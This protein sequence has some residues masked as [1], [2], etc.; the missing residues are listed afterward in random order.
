[1]TVNDGTIS[2]PEL[3]QI[4]QA[5]G[6]IEAAFTIAMKN[7]VDSLI[8]ATQSE[9]VISSVFL[10]SLIANY[11]WCALLCDAPDENVEECCW[12]QYKKNGNDLGTERNSG[13]DY[14]LVIKHSES[15]VRVAVIQAKRAHR[16][17]SNQYFV[18]VHRDAV[19][20]DG[21][22][23]VQMDS[24]VKT[25][26][27]FLEAA[28][29]TCNDIRDIH[30]IHY[31]G[32][33]ESEFRAVSLGYMGDAYKKEMVATPHWYNDFPI[34]KNN[35]LLFSEL[36]KESLAP[37]AGDVNSWVSVSQERAEDLLPHLIHIMD[38]F[39]VE[40][41][42]SG[43]ALKPKVQQSKL[44]KVIDRRDGEKLQAKLTKV[45]KLHLNRTLS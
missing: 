32:Y 1:M 29:R 7:T 39:T 15:D 8:A 36:L 40:R 6:P 21:V 3:L 18:D 13:A 44:G 22:S 24:L 41:G 26:K 45:G 2:A 23:H 9:E 4:T 38:V 12:G 34:T 20:V 35:S 16:N 43:K 37:K 17:R 14:A 31:L 25:G 27:L 19:L 28:G 5:C 10:G 30:F 42:R 11:P 33:L